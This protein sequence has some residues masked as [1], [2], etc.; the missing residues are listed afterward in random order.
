VDF[1]RRCSVN[2]I[3]FEF[4][5]KAVVA[6]VIGFIIGLGIG[7]VILGIQSWIF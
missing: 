4:I 7:L 6:A 1:E 2:T 3:I 5:G